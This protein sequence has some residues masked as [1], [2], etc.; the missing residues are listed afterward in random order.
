[1]VRL[2]LQCKVP[3][4]KEFHRQ[5]I[6]RQGAKV[7]EISEQTSTRL[8]FPD[9]DSDSNV[10]VIIGTVRSARLTGRPAEELRGR[11]RPAGQDPGRAGQCC[12]RGARH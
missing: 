12:D 9:E 6:G 7:K 2:R 11:P 1:M 8:K 3:V 10:I 4:F 5:I